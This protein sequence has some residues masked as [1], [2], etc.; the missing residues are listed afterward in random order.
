MRS[1]IEAL[2]SPT[3]GAEMTSELTEKQQCGVLDEP[4]TDAEPRTR[5]ERILIAAEKLFAAEGYHGVPMRAIARTAGVGLPLVTYHFE[6]KDNLYRS[7]FEYRQGL[8]EERRQSLR[9]VSDY[10]APD[11]LEQIVAAFVDPYMA[12]LRSEGAAFAQLV[13]REATDPTGESRGIICDYFDPMAREY[14]AA[15]REALPHQD[16]AYLRWAHM[17]TVGAMVASLIDSRVERFTEEPEPIED[18]ETKAGFLKRF[19]V[20]GLRSGMDDESTRKRRR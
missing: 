14:V 19:I 1:N 12:S 16:P 7:I 20:G 2:S 5:R 10:G 4:G 15:L 18:L 13:A 6:T 11:A 8:I 3:T 17:F 9:D